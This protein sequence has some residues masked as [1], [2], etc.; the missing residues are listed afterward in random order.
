MARFGLWPILGRIIGVIATL[1]IVGILLRLIGAILT[2][3][4]PPSFMQALNAGWQ[5]LYN[6]AGSAVPAIMAIIILGALLWI[7]LGRR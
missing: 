5:K 4:L 7:I 6:L 3:I 1:A 2:P